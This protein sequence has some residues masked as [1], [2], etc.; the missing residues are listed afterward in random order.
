M[1]EWTSTN[2]CVALSYLSYA[3]MKALENT[4]EWDIPISTHFASRLVLEDGRYITPSKDIAP[5]V[6]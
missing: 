3:S 5:D 1:V 2:E 6:S 4:L